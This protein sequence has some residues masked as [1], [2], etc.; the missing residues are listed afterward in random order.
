MLSIGEI[1]F[2]DAWNSALSTNPMQLDPNA[3]ALAKS[4]GVTEQK[5]DGWSINQMID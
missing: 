4:L 2:V 5:L 1:T 3:A